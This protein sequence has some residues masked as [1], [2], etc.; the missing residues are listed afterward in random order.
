[1]ADIIIHH[2]NKK[3]SL[4]HATYNEK[5]SGKKQLVW[6]NFEFQEFYAFLAILIT[7]GA[8][9]SNTDNTKDMWQSYSYPLYRAKMGINCFLTSFVL[10]DLMMAI[11]VLNTWRLTKLHQY[12]IFEQYLKVEIPKKIL[13]YAM[14]VSPGNLKIMFNM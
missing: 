14:F 12:E 13:G 9:N 2:T 4:T 5:N 3:A 6:K 8:N 11:L 10:F 7:F 1:M